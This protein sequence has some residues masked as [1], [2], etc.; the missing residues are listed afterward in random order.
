MSCGIKSYYESLEHQQARK[1]YR[2]KYVYIK[3][4]GNKIL[5]VWEDKPVI[6]PEQ[7]DNI[8]IIKRIL[9]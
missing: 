6:K 8:K 3:M 9:R 1:R 5:G 2:P 7:G 4:K